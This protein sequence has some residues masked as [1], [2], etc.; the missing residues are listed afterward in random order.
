MGVA[1]LL[2]TVGGIQH[3]FNENAVAP[4][5]IV[6]QHMGDGPDEFAV[7]HNGTAAHER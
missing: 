6:H 7:L 5:G 1:V 4:G 2:Q 3:I